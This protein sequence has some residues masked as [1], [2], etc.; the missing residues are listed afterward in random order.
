MPPLA[1]LTSSAQLVLNWAAL[2]LPRLVLALAVLIGGIFVARWISKE[3]KRI[4]AK[5]S[6]LDATL[7]PLLVSI[8]RYT[9]LAFVIVLALEQL[10][11][12]TTSLLAVLGAAGLAIGLAL[13][14]TLSNIAAGL[15]L[16]FLRPFRVG[17][18]IEVPTVSGLIGRVREIGLFA[19]RLETFDGLLVVAPNA[20][21]WNAPLRNHTRNEGRL[22]AL[23]I[24][25][26]AAADAAGVKAKLLE[27]AR[28]DGTT[29]RPPAVYVENLNS[30]TVEFV[31]LCW[32][33]SARISNLQHTIVER[34]R[35]ELTAMGPD[36]APQRILRRVP[37]DTDPARFMAA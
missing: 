2:F 32:T 30:H 21:I 4:V 11:V 19:C 10:G 12:Q 18:F 24:A 8:A 37:P 27:L 3:L 7:K 17:D 20:T 13:Q 31:L 1:P 9:V 36:F 16:L 15:M 6:R 25:V 22:L 29:T 33:A 28:E 23:S 14:G 26:S 5:S 34:I 35:R